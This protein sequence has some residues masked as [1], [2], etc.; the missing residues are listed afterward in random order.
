MW[1]AWSNFIGDSSK[2]VL[3]GL[4]KMVNDAVNWMNTTGD[5]AFRKMGVNLI[6]GLI[7]GVKSMAGDLAGSIKDLAK[8][9]IE[10]P[11]RA[12][13]SIF[14]PSR[15]FF[16]FGVNIG[17]GLIDGITSM[18]PAVGDAAKAMAAAVAD[19]G[20]GNVGNALRGAAG[21]G[22]AGG[23]FLSDQQYGAFLLG[24][25]FGGLGSS[26]GGAD[27]PSAIPSLGNFTLPALTLPT[28]PAVLK[29]AHAASGAGLTGTGAALGAGATPSGRVPLGNLGAQLMSVLATG[30]ALHAGTSPAERNQERAAQE[31]VTQTKQGGDQVS[32]LQKMVDLQQQSYNKLAQL[33]DAVIRGALP[34]TPPLNVAQAMGVFRPAR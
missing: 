23:T 33:A 11:F 13:M 10:S 21:A 18:L 29:V 25:M 31:L 1:T 14:S 26:G 8:N 2:G 9:A 12:A 3:D 7:D 22:V 20:V 4:G 28:L 32:A 34:Q 15:V 6:Q 17:Q 16:G 24:N 5:A 30:G 27:T 19:S